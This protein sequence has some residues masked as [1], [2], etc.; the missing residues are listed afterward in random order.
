MNIGDWV[1]CKVGE[2]TALGYIT[3]LPY[4]NGQIH[5]TRVAKRVEGTLIWMKPESRIYDQNKT[6]VLDNTLAK[7]DYQD[8]IDLAI[9][10]ADRQWF[11]ELSERMM[12]DA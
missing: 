6:A 10:T 9:M 8:L 2:E 3:G 12:V 4:S 5:V 11:F 1:F 7:E